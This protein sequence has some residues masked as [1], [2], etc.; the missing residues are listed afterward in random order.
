[1]Q[2]DHTKHIQLMTGASMFKMPCKT[3]YATCRNVVKCESWN[4]KWRIEKQDFW[5]WKWIY[6][7][8]LQIAQNEKQIW[9]ASTKI[10]SRFEW[11][12]KAE[13][14]KCKIEKMNW[15]IVLKESWT[16]KKDWRIY[17]IDIKRW[18]R[19]SKKIIKNL[20]ICWISSKLKRTMIQWQDKNEMKTE[21]NV[22]NL[23][24]WAK[25]ICSLNDCV[26]L[27]KL[28]LKD[29]AQMIQCSL[30]CWKN[31]HLKMWFWCCFRFRFDLWTFYILF[32]DKMKL[33]TRDWKF[34]MMNFKE[35]KKH[36]KDAEI[37][38]L[39]QKV[40]HRKVKFDEKKAQY[41]ADT[42]DLK[43]KIK[44]QAHALNK[45]QKENY[46]LNKKV[47]E[48][49]F[50]IQQYEQWFANWSRHWDDVE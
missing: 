26:K 3:R 5:C 46:D 23:K 27:T 15:K 32:W 48:Q 45:L 18:R 17:F 42:K 30:N 1:M 28:M 47:E 37:R 43:E 12:H 25:N 36:E 6:K 49:Y 16:F 4:R 10:C 20:L 24:F 19:K 31:I 39:K 44:Q 9:L 35:E 21:C 8:E 2:Q 41:R 34:S 38:R 14:R 33:R 13:W 7:I 29:W 11:K 40:I 22:S 50:E